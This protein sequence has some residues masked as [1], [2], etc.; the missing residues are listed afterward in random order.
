MADRAQNEPERQ[1]A[2]INGDGLI[3]TN[4]ANAIIDVVLGLKSTQNPDTLDF[5]GDGAITVNDAV[6]FTKLYLHN[7][8]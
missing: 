2:D 4:D 6:M 5:D 8:E 1:F 3:D 7:N